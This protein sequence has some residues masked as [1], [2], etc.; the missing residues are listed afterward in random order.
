MMETWMARA[1]PLSS[2]ATLT[3]IHEGR[4]IVGETS[5]RLPLTL[6]AAGNNPPAD[7]LLATKLYVPAPAGTLVPRP[8]LLA[9]L[10]AALTGKLTTVIAPA[11]WGKTTL[12]GA[13][14]SGLANRVAGG[15]W[16]G[17]PG[18]PS[19]R[20]AWLS[21]EAADGEPTRFWTYV[22]SALDTLFPG[23]GTTP[24]ALLRS[25]QPP[26]IETVLTTLVN[27]L[28]SGDGATLASG[29][30]AT[31]A[32]GDGAALTP[33]PSPAVL[34]LDDY[35]VIDSP[36]VHAALA[37]LLDHLPAQLHLV[38]ASRADPPMSLSR[39]RSHGTL[40]ELR[41]ADLRFTPEEA[42]VFL[43]QVLG[44][45]LSTE[46][47]LALDEHTEGWIAG[48]QL[49][50]LA[51]RGR[52]DI[53][54]FI[55]GFTG[56]SR[57]IID[58]L[59]EE[60]LERQPEEVRAFLLRT[61]ILERMCA[62]MCDAVLTADPGC[63]VPSGASQAML[64]TLERANLFIVALD[65]ERVWYRYHH[66]F[67][68]VLRARLRQ[69]H[70]DLVPSL[71]RRAAAWCEG[72]ELV[73]AALRYALAAGDNEGAARIVEARARNVMFNRGDFAAIGSWLAMLP[74][75]AID[76]R[77]ELCLAYATVFVNRSDTA[78]VEAYLQRAEEALPAFPD[79][80]VGL[81][82]EILTIRGHMAVQYGRWS[83]GLELL[84]S[85]L[86][87]L[88]TDDPY[89]GLALY[90]LGR[91][92]LLVGS[93]SEA[94]AILAEAVE[95]NRRNGY[96]TMA[97]LSLNGVAACRTVEGRL[98]EAVATCHEGLL[99]AESQGI[100]LTATT[101]NLHARLSVIYYEWDD[102]DAAL[103]HA[104]GAQRVVRAADFRLLFVAISDLIT[105]I[106]YAQGD[107]EGARA[108]MLETERSAAAERIANPQ[109][110]AVFAAD[111]LHH[112]FAEATVA[113]GGKRPLVADYE[114]ARERG[115][116]AGDDPTLEHE[117]EYL[118][119]A[120]V[121]LERGGGERGD[122]IQL[123][124]RLLKLEESSGGARVAVY[125][126]ALRA[127]GYAAEGNR[128]QA[129][130]S[131]EQALAL[132]EPE[133][134]VR[135]FLD[136]G[137][138]MQALLREARSAARGI[139]PSYVE[140]L[141]RQFDA[142]AGAEHVRPAKPPGADGQYVEPLTPRELEVLRLIAAG[143]S[144]REIAENLV[145]AVGTVKRHT[146]SLYGK[147]GA[148]SRTQAIARARELELF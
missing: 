63:P 59:A 82:A 79:L 10:D 69:A 85:A 31:L 45:H 143:A 124:D 104:R 5:P 132:A 56:S 142:P 122:G 105:Q 57:F 118:A 2:N 141:L 91:F 100:Q 131:L 96:L 109:F 21:L 19:A 76:V 113:L 133:G 107:L 120:R 114:R 77:P 106:L 140:T 126:L 37:F 139:A 58:Y 66:L 41:A 89:R 75:A 1:A 20:V 6:D 62:P 23:A 46:D 146:N 125:I 24:L 138:P 110:K 148:A 39:M 71:Y 11:G 65:D 64:E 103:R 29:D 40:T 15:A 101:A 43:R 90:S 88:P 38:I 128:V 32:S 47:V 4:E 81:Q 14:C 28:A 123:L 136:E 86:A 84:R 52:P 27:A 134:Y 111:R 35:H 54:G 108:A 74:Q 25:T 48:L 72:Q 22:I 80:A 115:L 12:L 7:L 18:P 68:D 30:G 98:R 49:A 95:L 130:A 116:T 73:T 13:W 127:L 17:G 78:A 55:A 147:L 144:N 33:L 42:S 36:R 61:S 8:S 121:L 70:R 83:Q 16:P 94:G 51:M 26:A 67:A 50:A 3:R 87:A 119:L 93:R 145:V 117:I 97:I 92:H 44:F 135:T 53:S 9:R 34:V 102:L 112:Q 99:L 137:P 60:V 129:L